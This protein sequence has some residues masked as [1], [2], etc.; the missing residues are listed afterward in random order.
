[1]RKWHKLLIIAVIIT[2]LSGLGYFVYGYIDIDGDGL[3]NKEEK[4]YKT[5]PYNKD[6]DGDTLSD[7]DEIYVY[8]TNAT[9]SDTSGD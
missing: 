7:Y 9:L 5:D 8:N 4:K 2:C 6:T 1:M 3:S